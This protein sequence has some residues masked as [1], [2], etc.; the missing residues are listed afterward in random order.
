MNHRYYGGI[1]LPHFGPRME[2][3][4]FDW[5]RPRWWIRRC[6][7][8]FYQHRVTE[9]DKVCMAASYLD[10]VANAWFQ[11]WSHGRMDLSWPEFVSQLCVEGLERR[12]D[13]M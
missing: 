3:L 10:D 5:D 6:E 1:N 7:R 11:H 4:A 2:I 8:V 9:G 12:P 13:L